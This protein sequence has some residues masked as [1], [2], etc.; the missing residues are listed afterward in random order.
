MAKEHP[1]KRSDPNKI[2]RD[3]TGIMKDVLK[4]TGVTHSPID[5]LAD[6]I[7]QNR[8]HGLRKQMGVGSM[9]RRRGAVQIGFRKHEEA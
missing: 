5:F 2:R 4:R 8:L 1:G 9:P 6:K 7:Q 3:Q